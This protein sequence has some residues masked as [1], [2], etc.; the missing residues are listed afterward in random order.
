MSVG[1][2]S[3][4]FASVVRQTSQPVPTQKNVSPAEKQADVNLIQATRPDIISVP[5]SNPNVGKPTS[6]KEVCN[7][8]RG[9]CGT[10]KMD[11]PA[12]KISVMDI[13]QGFETHLTNLEK[14][15]TF[16]EKKG[17]S[18]PED[19]KMAAENVKSLSVEQFGTFL[20]KLAPHLDE[21]PPTI[22][23]IFIQI[24]EATSIKINEI[25]HAKVVQEIENAAQKIMADSTVSQ[26][27]KEDLGLTGSTVTVT[28]TSMIGEFTPV[29]VQSSVLNT[30]IPV[31]QLDVSKQV[32]LQ[33]KTAKI[34]LPDVASFVDVSKAVVT[35]S[36]V[37]PAPAPVQAQTLQSSVVVGSLFKETA[38]VTPASVTLAEPTGQAAGKLNGAAQV[39]SQSELPTAL[40]RFQ[41]STSEDFGKIFSQT[42][43][44]KDALPVQ[45]RAA[46][47]ISVKIDAGSKS[48]L[49]IELPTFV[50][51][52]SGPKFIPTQDT[53][54]A[55][56]LLV[57]MSPKAVMADLMGAVA[58]RVSDL[59]PQE[60]KQLV[61]LVKLTSKQSPEALPVLSAVIKESTVPQLQ[62]FVGVHEAFLGKTPSKDL[63]QASPIVKIVVEAV[64][65]ESSPLS[66]M[67]VQ[68]SPKE[69]L[70]MASVIAVLPE[71]TAQV[72]MQ[73]PAILAETVKMTASLEPKAMADTVQNLGAI[74]AKVD[75]PTLQAAVKTLATVEPKVMADVVK[76]MA[77]MEPNVLSETVQHLGTLAA[78]V[79]APTLQAAVKTL[80]TVEPKVMADVVKTMAGMEPKV[81]ADVV[82]TM[83]GMEPKVV[84]EMVQHLGTLAA[85]V[86]APTL[87]AAVKTLAAVEP[88]VMADAVKTMAG[89]EPKV[90]TE[91][92]R[93]LGV[94]AA[95]VD[96]PTLQAAVKTLAAVEP[97]VMADAVKTLAGMQPKVVAQTVQHLGTLAAKVDTPTLQ[98]AVKTLA[99]VEPKVMAEAVKTVAAMEPKVLAETVQSLGQ[100]AAKVDTPILQAAVKTL[101]AM[102]PKV[103][104]EAVKTMAAMEPKVLSETVQH[105]GAIAAKVDAPVLNQL[106]QAAVI[107]ESGTRSAETV[108][109]QISAKFPQLA[110]SANAVVS[111]VLGT[112][113]PATAP[114]VMEAAPKLMSNAPVLHHI[115]Q[116]VEANHP[117]MSPQVTTALNHIASKA[118]TAVLNNLSKVMSTMDSKTMVRTSLFL[119]QIAARTEAPV[120]NQILQIVSKMQP[121]TVRPE[122]IVKHTEARFSQVVVPSGLLGSHVVTSQ[123]SQ[124]VTNSATQRMDRPV[125]MQAFEE[126]KFNVKSPEIQPLLQKL[127]GMSSKITAPV[128][129]AL[130]NI[131]AKVSAPVLNNVLQMLGQLEPKTMAQVTIALGQ[132]AAKVDIKV[133]TML[134]QSLGQLEPKTMAQVAMA[135]GQIAAKVDAPANSL[136]QSLGQL[137]PKLMAQVTMALGQIAAKV[138]GPALNSLIQS[139][140]KL[141][142]KLMVQVVLVLGQIAA[143]VDAPALNSLIQSLG[144]LEPKLMVQV[145]LVLGQIAAKVD[146]PALNSLIQTLGKLEPKVMAQVTMVLGQISSK[147]DSQSMTTLIQ[148]LGKLDPK[149]MVQ[150]TTLLNSL[151]NQ[152]EPAMLSVVIKSLSII[153]PKLIQS[154]LPGLVAG[155]NGMDKLSAQHIQAL[156]QQLLEGVVP[157]KASFLKRIQ[158]LGAEFFQGKLD[159]QQ[160]QSVQL[161]GSIK[162]MPDGLDP[163]L[164]LAASQAGG[165]EAFNL[166]RKVA[167]SSASQMRGTLVKKDALSRLVIAMMGETIGQIDDTSGGLMEWA[168]SMR[169]RRT[170]R[171]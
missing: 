17:I 85:K 15:M 31:P 25:N 101:A 150:V 74:A 5:T 54:G 51:S 28:K 147:I 26:F 87:Q 140:G 32:D 111:A 39:L 148:M 157:D 152:L 164:L 68:L 1:G 86:D 72:L 107:P 63:Q 135:L 49:T 35:K 102:E 12:S 57:T 13:L 89:M 3:P 113:R 98:V 131:A 41:V 153:D 55:Q 105:L 121:G 36:D 90:V 139:L 9:C 59:L 70:V 108:V 42:L 81:M 161:N 66:K 144:K 22:S 128:L 167:G 53:S 78:K 24:K 69:T 10:T 130:N 60:A 156:L 109:K 48:S 166:R 65:S 165:D 91:T 117:T 23:N 30:D 112:E 99:T 27:L 45:E 64:K 103:M 79:D 88:K 136:L 169:Q 124:V 168:E 20:E 97:K 67:L 134:L 122:T 116:T 46:V 110:A 82:K 142:P 137:E 34:V 84:A 2:V 125:V 96:A 6:C 138:D 19:L 7:G 143:K 71:K 93:H 118:D 141:E 115:A 170:S 114:V 163:Q 127:D 56:Q 155:L 14:I 11:T 33:G 154:I 21:L 145:V 47:D 92:V 158:Q 8:E 62:A 133:M 37:Q 73:Q 162:M 119:G 146:A 40:T 171:Q 159:A 29:S 106:I 58:T 129:T 151:A 160:A 61:A 18:I 44:Q 52:D 77:G 76:T 132:I 120:M 50:T 95:K 126:P 123:T 104:A 38:M 94:L 16:A 149:A 83:A 75:A 80:A 43:G 100:I 4:Q